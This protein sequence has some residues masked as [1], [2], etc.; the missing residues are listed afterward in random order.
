MTTGSFKECGLIVSRPDHKPV[1][2]VCHM[3]FISPRPLAFQAMH[4]MPLSEYLQ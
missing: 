4:I 3:T 1:T 2:G